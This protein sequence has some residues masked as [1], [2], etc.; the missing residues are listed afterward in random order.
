MLLYKKTLW[1][2]SLE[3]FQ[4]VKTQ[5]IIKDNNDIANLAGFSAELQR[6]LF[7]K[8][9]CPVEGMPIEIGELD[10]TMA[11][12]DAYKAVC[13]KK[14]IEDKWRKNV[15]GEFSMTLQKNIFLK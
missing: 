5:G 7:N 1:H 2:K 9:N 3:T 15:L 6:T 14:K 10:F 4:S 13:Q 8:E 12:M 11:R